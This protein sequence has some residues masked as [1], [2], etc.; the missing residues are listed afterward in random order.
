MASQGWIAVD[1]KIFD[2]LIWKND[3]PF[4]RRSAWI[5]LLLLVNHADNKVLI[6]GKVEI[7]KRG[8]WITS[9]LFLAQRWRWSRTKTKAFLKM[10]E[11]EG[12]IRLDVQAKKKTIITI[13]NYSKYQ[14]IQNKKRSQKKDMKKDIPEPLQLQA[15]SET[16]YKKKNNRK[17]TEKQPKDKNNN[18]NNDNNDKDDDIKKRLNKIN[19]LVNKKVSSS[20][21][22]RFLKSNSLDDLDRL[23]EK[24]KESDYLKQNIDFN[25]LS[26]KFLKKVFD[27]EYRTY[28]EVNKNTFK[29]FE[30]ITDDYTSDELEDMAMRK[31]KEGFKR[32]GVEIWVKICL[33]RN[34]L[35]RKY[36]T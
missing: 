13:T 3:D 31:Q 20:Q 2:N 33:E 23:V 8:Q 32:L 5:D 28:E 27:D 24:I 34:N 10:L 26:K 15:C 7:V 4:D 17:T 16:E 22:K 18:H 29:N 9:I 21:I 12:M 1:R 30:Q 36:K 35:K 19:N 11:S 25:K 14:D 6:N